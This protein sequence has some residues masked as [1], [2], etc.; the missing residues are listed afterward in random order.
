MRVLRELPVA[1]NRQSMVW[2]WCN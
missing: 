1:E 2:G